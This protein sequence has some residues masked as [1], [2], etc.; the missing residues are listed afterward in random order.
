MEA[1]PGPTWTISEVIE[2]VG[3]SRRDIQ[4]CCYKG[5]GGVDLLD[6]QDTT[7][8]KRSYSVHD[9]ARLFLA[10]RI[11]AQGRS[12]PEAARELKAAEGDGDTCQETLRI[13]CERLSERQEELAGLRVRAEALMCALDPERSRSELQ[14]LLVTQAIEKDSP[15]QKLL[16]HC[17]IPGTNDTRTASGGDVLKVDEVV[18]G[19]VKC[20]RYP[21]Q[22]VDAR[23]GAAGFELP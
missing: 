6:P 16:A 23:V 1:Q 8:G 9:V 17:A 10:G 7:W 14:E 13:C 19:D 22:N 21:N 3:L 11:K 4:R 2:L 18:H 12:L 15:L 20:P 5:R